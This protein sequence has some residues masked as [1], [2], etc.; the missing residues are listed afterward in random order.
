MKKNFLTIVAQ[1]EI[2]D[3]KKN[4]LISNAIRAL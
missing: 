3:V 2:F 1:G 4:P